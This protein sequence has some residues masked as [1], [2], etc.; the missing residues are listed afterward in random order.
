M[1]VAIGVA[2]FAAVG[3]Y[4]SAR[5]FSNGFAPA[6]AVCAGLSLAGAVA[7]LL[8]PR[9]HPQAGRP[10]VTS[11]TGMAST[12]TSSTATASPAGRS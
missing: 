12:A 2:V 3:G 10:A 9:R 4:A 8:L 7:G 5:A 11:S 1:G 6:L